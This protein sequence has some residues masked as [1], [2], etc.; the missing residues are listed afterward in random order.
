[1]KKFTKQKGITLIALIITIIVMIILVAVTIN[2]ALNG[3]IFE[4]AKTASTKTQKAAEKEELI[5]IG[6][7]LYDVDKGIDKDKLEA[8]LPNTY[9]IDRDKTDPEFRYIVEGKSG[10]LWEINLKTGEVKENPWIGWGLT[11]PN[12]KYNTLFVA[13]EG[14]DKLMVY[15]DGSVFVDWGIDDETGQPTATKI[16][17]NDVE[18]MIE[19]GG[20]IIETARINIFD[21][22]FIFDFIKE[23]VNDEDVRKVNLYV[24]G[25]FADTL[26][27]Q[28]GDIVIIS[29]E[30][31]LRKYVLGEN[32]EGRNL[33][34]DNDIM[35]EGHFRDNDI[36]NNASTT[37]HFIRLVEHNNQLYVYVKYDTTG[38]YYCIYMDTMWN[39]FDLAEVYTPS[40]SENVGRTLTYGGKSYTVISENGSDLELVGNYV[41]SNTLTL[42]A[43]TDSNALA[44]YNNAITTLN[45]AAIEA[46]G[47]TVDGT[48]VK[49][50]R[51]VGTSGNSDNSGNY[52][53]PE[54]TTFTTYTGNAKVAD[55][56][57]EVDLMKLYEANT[58]DIGSEY[59]IASRNILYRPS[60]SLM[61]K[62]RYTN[63]DSANLGD[64]I[65]YG[66]G[67][68]VTAFISLET[69]SYAVR[70]VII[71]NSNASG[72]VWD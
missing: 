56:F 37:L 26:I 40:E 10:T 67:D 31:K 14:D 9:K 51:S 48:N 47:L 33:L 44:V 65:I 42:E 15:D 41:S 19:N 25:E 6:I 62:I 18:Q 58:F 35:Q 29:P 28:E 69:R 22:Q 32:E 4:R 20:I 21:G 13:T 71:L 53:N 39:A 2:V 24:G 59:W 64:R 46:T 17:K 30:D 61:F 5:S 7:G 12:V 54:S 52:P 63:K 23:T 1:M 66:M 11:S 38:K 8:N 43:G 49:S 34:T 3:G 57:Y 36:I 68:S 27:E 55:L 16:N 60:E 72:I 70:P 45:N 50:I